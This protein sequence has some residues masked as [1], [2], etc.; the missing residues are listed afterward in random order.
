MKTGDC[1]RIRVGLWEWRKYRG[2][3]AEIRYAARNQGIELLVKREADGEFI[4]M[5]RT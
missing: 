1:Y 4:G 5:V 2:T 3:L